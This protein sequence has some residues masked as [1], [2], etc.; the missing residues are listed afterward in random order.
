MDKLI[1]EFK[2]S[3]DVTEI[4][5]NG[6]SRRISSFAL[7]NSSFSWIDRRDC[8]EQLGNISTEVFIDACLLAGSNLIDTFPPLR[9]PRQYNAGYSLRDAVKLL[10]IYGPGI[11]GVCAQY[12]DDPKVKRVSYLDKYK[13]V[14]TGI[15]H[16]VVITNGGNVETLDAVHAPNDVHECIGQRLPEELT[17]YLSRGMI[18]PRVLNWLT[19]G[20]ILITVPYAGGEAPEYQNLVREQLLPWRRQ[21]LCLLAD[22]IHRYYQSKEVTTKFW[23]DESIEQKLNLKDLLPS[24]K[25][26]LRTW[27]VSD[28]MISDRQIDL[29]ACSLNFQ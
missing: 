8:L 14:M 17:M 15:K 3:Y 5:D 26:T 24:Q 2:L 20:T 18:Q 22:S 11:S 23:F 19:S 10:L 12:Q 7:V 13:R 1:T 29:E 6:V 4:S 28:Q 16:H 21:A 25:I 9:D 27:H